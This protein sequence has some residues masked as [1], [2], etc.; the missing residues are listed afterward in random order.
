MNISYD[1]YRV[2]YYVAKYGSISH[3]AKFLLN[4]QPNLTRTIKNLESQ[5]GCPLFSRTNRGMKLTI[6]GEK[7]YSHVRIAF[8]HIEAAE[9]EITNST[10]LASGTVFV[11][12]SEVALR[13]LLLPV[14]KKYR[15]LYPKI[16]LRISNYSTPQAMCAINEGVADF[17]VITTPTSV[18][19]SLVQT[20]IKHIHETAI[21]PPDFT[22][23][24]GKK[25]SLADFKNYP[26]ISLGSDTKSFEFY[27][28]FFSSY[29]LVYRPDIEAFT[30]DQIL[31]MVEANLGIGF[32]PREFIHPSDNVRIVELIEKIPS[33]SI[34]LIK[35][36]Y[37]PLSVAAKELERMILS[38][39]A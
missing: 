33:R 38:L 21:C 1:Y 15:M 26:L 16:K 9:A 5:L 32:V 6:E 29:G 8:E 23:L 31:P 7:L 36:K 30:A 37:Q 19:A 4:N 14:L 35:R 27:S 20:N 11:A 24:I 25:V 39:S 2:F 28:E 17:A 22:A 12:A 3:A 18:S 34:C 13:C 10:N